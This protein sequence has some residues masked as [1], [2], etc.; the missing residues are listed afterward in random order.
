LLAGLGPASASGQ[1]IIGCHHSKVQPKVEGSP[2]LS[3]LLQPLTLRL[4]P[5]S[6]K[7]DEVSN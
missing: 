4:L 1:P 5:D 2:N 6:E 7:K 3:V